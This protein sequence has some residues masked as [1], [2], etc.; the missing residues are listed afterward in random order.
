LY[1]KHFHPGDQQTYPEPEHTEETK[2]L[3]EERSGI[4][5]AKGF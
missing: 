2:S 3:P 1:Y 4:S 5:Y